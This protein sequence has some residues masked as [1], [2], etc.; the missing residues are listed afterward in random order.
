MSKE[1]RFEYTKDKY[2]VFMAWIYDSKTDTDYITT[3]QED[4]KNL[5]K[6]LNEQDQQLA[7][8]NKEIETL[9]TKLEKANHERHEEWKTGKEWKWEWQKTNRLLK[10]A[11]KTK[12]DLAITQLEK[13]KVL[14]HNAVNLEHPEYNLIGVY[15]AINKQIKELKD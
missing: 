3:S 9:K 7:E 8:K 11:N 12:I 14:L 2:S 6:L 4:M 13:V 10:E 1:K 15:D 5:T